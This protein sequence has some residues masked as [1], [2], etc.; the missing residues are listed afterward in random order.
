[1]VMKDAIVPQ[2]HVEAEFRASL[3]AALRHGETLTGFALRCK[4][5]L[6]EYELSGASIPAAQ[7]IAK[8]ESKLA[9]RRNQ[10]GG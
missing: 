6:A 8:L 1:M 4:A 9:K 7:V 10:L 5:S 3:D 2:A